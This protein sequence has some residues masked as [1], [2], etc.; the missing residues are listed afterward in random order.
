MSKKLN[1]RR[2]RARAP[3]KDF[4]PHSRAF[5]IASRLSGQDVPKSKAAG[6]LSRAHADST[7][8]SA[9]SSSAPSRNTQ[10]GG[11]GIAAAVVLGFGIG[12]FDNE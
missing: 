10:A 6:T 11:L 12:L 2:A 9:P 3:H 1:L 7:G 4:T 8:K 5:A